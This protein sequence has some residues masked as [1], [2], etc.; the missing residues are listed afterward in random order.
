MK[1]ALTVAQKFLDLASEQGR[2]LTPM[3]LIKLVYIAH[4]WMLGLRDRPLIRENVEAW[5]YGPV[6]PELYRSIKQYRDKPVE[7]ILNLP[8][9]DLGEAEVAL[10][11]EV[12]DR[13]GRFSGI[14]LSMMT[15]TK[16]TPWD[17][18]WNSDRTSLLISNDLIQS[19]YKGLVQ[20]DL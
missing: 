8:D 19:H 12:Y 10:T 6:I 3:Q 9:E 17:N 7:R 20:G 16:G 14:Q 5:P 11:K 1:S 13:Y 18:T 2:T 4:G 15:H